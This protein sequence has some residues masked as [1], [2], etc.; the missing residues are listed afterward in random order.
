VAGHTDEEIAEILGAV[1]QRLQEM[2]AN[3]ASLT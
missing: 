1:P 3:A 2:F